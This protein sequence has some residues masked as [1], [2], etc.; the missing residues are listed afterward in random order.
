MDPVRPKMVKEKREA[1]PVSARAPNS[2]GDVLI[3]E[4][5]KVAKEEARWDRS[6]ARF[7]SDLARYYRMGFRPVTLGDYVH[8]R[9]DLPKGASPLVITFD[10][11]HISQYRILDDGQ[12]DPDCAIGIWVAF[13]KDHPDFPV[14]A[15]FFVLPS[16]PWGQK[17]SLATKI[18]Q[19]KDW[20][21][22]LGSHTMTHPK[23]SSLSEK[24]VKLELSQAID[25]VSSLGG[26]CEAIALPYGVSPKD[27]KLLSGFQ[28]NGRS[29]GHKAALLVGANP[30][31]SPDSI[32]R[33]LMRLPRI[34]CIEGPYGITDWLD[35]IQAGSVQVYVR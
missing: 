20:G 4:Y 1:A 13:A 8:N 15:T 28:L 26:N 30:A 17:A 32:K 5:H 27:T 14:K 19:L 11:S 24:M 9:M 2:Q 22:E 25:F 16:V 21:C 3:V 12:V 23:L 34:Q 6:I 29:Y 18:K 33:N 31:P 7:K 10:D 35:R